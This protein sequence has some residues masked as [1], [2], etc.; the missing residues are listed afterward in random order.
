MA[1][2]IV[3]RSR[4]S[5]GSD[6]ITSLSPVR[7]TNGP[8]R[9]YR[10]SQESCRDDRLLVADNSARTGA[11]SRHLFNERGDT[12]FAGSATDS[13]QVQS[14]CETHRDERFY[15]ES[16]PLKEK[17]DQSSICDE[18]VGSSEPL[19][20]IQAH[21]AKVA[22][23]D[24]T[25]LITGETGTGKE[26]VARAMHNLSPRSGRPFIRVNCGAIPQSLIG[27]ELFGHEKGAFTGATQ[28]RP[29]RFELADGGTLFLD[30]V[31][32]LPQ[33]TQVALLRVLQER[34]FERIGGSKPVT[35][36]VRIVA[37]TNRHLRDAVRD[38]KFREDLF[39]RLNVFPIHMPTLRERVDD[40][41]LLVRHLAERC[42]L[43]VG[44]TID[45]IEK[46]TLN[47][48]Q[49]YHW[50]GNIRELQNV[51]ERAVIIWCR[52]ETGRS[53]IDARVENPQP[54]D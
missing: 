45:R 38:N 15:L 11:V 33:E 40:I 19:R 34:E 37:A 6:R 16:V 22:P 29:G 43:K 2:T 50:P 51:I 17:I 14:L 18:I 12:K 49:G 10:E 23:T 25:V 9:P 31:G 1:P 26:L 36:D 3:A 27:S 53:A 46:R 52:R 4:I 8:C 7:L 13:T 39:Y 54:A 5:K 24:S 35:V 48:L 42:A 44:K 47:L 30:E 32:E 20:R 21:I 41:P 28:Q